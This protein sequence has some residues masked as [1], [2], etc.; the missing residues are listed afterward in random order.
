MGFED[1]TFAA[2]STSANAHKYKNQKLGLAWQ[3]VGSH[4]GTWE[5]GSFVGGSG[6]YAWEVTEVE[7]IYENPDAPVKDRV[8]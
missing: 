3:L 8:V 7:K 2:P 5:H 1:M 6:N 4:A